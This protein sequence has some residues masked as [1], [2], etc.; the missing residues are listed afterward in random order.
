MVNYPKLYCRSE[1]DTPDMAFQKQ[2]LVIICSF[3][4][5]CGVIWWL[6][7]YLI[8][9]WTIP[10]VAAGLFGIMVF[11]MI[12]VSHR[13]RNHMLLV[14]AA[15]F[16]TFVV[17]IICQ[18]SFANMHDSGMIIAWSFLTPLGI[19]IFSSIRP[20][21]IYMLLFIACILITALDPPLIGSQRL[22][23]NDGLIKLFYSMDLVTSFSVTFSTCAWF[24]HTIKLEKQISESLLLNI[25][26]NDVAV[27]LKKFGKVEPVSHENAT[28]LFTDFKGFTEISET[29][30]A[31]ELVAEINHCFGAF[32]EIATRHNIEKIKTI[33]DSYMAV[34]GNFSGKECTPWHVVSAG[35][36]MQ[37]YIKKRKLERD[38]EGAFSFEMRVG[39]HS[40][41][42][43]SGVVGVKKFQ[44]D[45]WGDT[46]NIASRMQSASEP[47][48]TNISG[49]TYEL[50]KDK[51]DFEFRGSLPVK[52]KGDMP[53]YFVRQRKS[54]SG[55]TRGLHATV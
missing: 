54:E 2:L 49:R 46:V 7:W 39:V 5:L 30:T 33:G 36:E 9:G 15:F 38:K 48:E 50:L 52:G 53:M 23:V 10:T 51:F 42:V 29:I 20:A 19:L 13:A 16:G 22:V 44:F 12:I 40:G 47:G 41:P 21:I 34:G 4:V 3:L 37:D 18:W 1:D 8:F 35:L 24:V 31:K 28:V 45:I 11:V 25:L 14:H 27:E 32:D 43:V 55:I 17:P 6:M 26:P